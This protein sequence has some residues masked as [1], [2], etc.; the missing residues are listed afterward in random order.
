MDKLIQFCF[1][2]NEGINKDFVM[3]A[4]KLFVVENQEYN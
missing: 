2:I 3:E 4:K 1:K